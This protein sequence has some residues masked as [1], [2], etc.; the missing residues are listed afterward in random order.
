MRRRWRAPRLAPPGRTAQGTRARALR[1]LW[2]DGRRLDAD[3]A[4]A[5]D[6]ADG[7]GPARAAA[8]ARE[9]V[10]RR[11]AAQAGVALRRGRRAAVAGGGGGGGGGRVVRG[12]AR[13]RPAALRAARPRPPCAT[14]C[15]RASSRRAP[16]R[17]AHNRP[18]LGR[19]PDGA[20]LE[21][22]RLICVK[23]RGPKTLPPAPR[24]TPR[25]PPPAAQRGDGSDDGDGGGLAAGAA[26][27]SRLLAV[28]EP[29]GGAASDASASPSR[30]SSTRAVS[31]ALEAPR[32]G[33]GI[34]SALLARVEDDPCALPKCRGPNGGG[35]DTDPSSTGGQTVG[36]AAVSPRHDPGAVEPARALRRG[37]ARVCLAPAAA[38]PPAAVAARPEPQPD[39][40]L[41]RRG[42][43]DAA[44]GTGA[45]AV[46]Q[47]L[48]ALLAANYVA[49]CAADLRARSPR[50]PTPRGAPSS[51]SSHTRSRGRRGRRRRRRRSAVEPQLGG[52]PVGGDGAEGR[53]SSCAR[54]SRR[55]PPPPSAASSASKGSD[56]AR[57]AAVA[58]FLANLAFE[59]D[60]AEAVVRA[61]EAFDTLV[62]ALRCRHAG[63][64]RA[65]SRT[66]Q[67][68]LLRRWQ[69]GA[70]REEG[71]APRALRRDRRRRRRARR[72]R[73][74][75]RLGA[76]REVRAREGGAA[77]ASSLL[78]QLHEAEMTLAA[79]TVLR[80]AAEAP[81]VAQALMRGGRDLLA[82]GRRPMK[83]WG[84]DECVCT[85]L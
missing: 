84:P 47:Q 5:A 52:A 83:G 11:E 39:Q 53:A 23:H 9:A 79:R 56:D 35:L 50:T 8:A 61:P 70:P 33:V 18:L 29:G 38:A 64:R 36:A 75:R 62:F 74:R 68:R 78:Q 49:H 10:E 46:R 72:A 81:H 73:R 28:R 6:A 63:C 66:A 31:V 14:P 55:R 85:A 40:G 13:G 82:A 30:P 19:R 3:G 26:L 37:E 54:S 2:A 16:R 41:R 32:A 21:S 80:D 22:C 20:R 44:K 4:A 65:A 43:A 42:P 71:G 25:P 76:P 48:L 77:L 1:R 45:G 12:G 17:G 24:S 15:S 59:P 58:D 7:G 51:R 57:A 34:A 67:P 27:A 69:G 60:G